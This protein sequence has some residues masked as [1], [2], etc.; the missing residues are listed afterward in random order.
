MTLTAAMMLAALAASAQGLPQAIGGDF[1]T[2]QILRKATYQKNGG[3][4]GAVAVG[5]GQVIELR[6]SETATL[7][8]LAP[9]KGLIA[10]ASAKI[11]AKKPAR[12]A[13]EQLKRVS[14]RRGNGW[15]EKL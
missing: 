6:V 15:T 8:P 5:T 10:K 2:K 3:V 9:A 13:A 11:K 1:L 4:T 12:R 7:A 14:S